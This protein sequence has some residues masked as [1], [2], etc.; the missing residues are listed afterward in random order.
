MSEQD[1]YEK[2]RSARRSRGLTV[3]EL[4]QEIGEDHQKVGRIE[5]GKR[6]LTIDYLLKVSKALDTPIDTL[7]NEEGDTN[8][9]QNSPDLL[10]EIVILVE[11]KNALAPTPLSARHKGKI[12]SKTNEA[13]SKLPPSLQK[14]FIESLLEN[15]FQ[16]YSLEESASI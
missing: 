13:A 7:I 4:A 9:S 15:L 1:I 6:S 5:R 11:E 3:N 16:L 2:I 12:I 8:S 10:N 14:L